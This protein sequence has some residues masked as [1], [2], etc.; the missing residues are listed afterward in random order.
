[1]AALPKQQVLVACPRCGHEQPEHRTAYSTVCKK[2]RQYYRVQEVLHPAVVEPRVLPTHTPDPV[3]ELRQ[4]ACFQC[5]TVLDVPAHAQST[6]CKRCSTHIDLQDHVIN[7]SVSRN[8]RTKGR[9]VVEEKGFLFNTDSLAREVVLR[10]KFLGKIASEDALV[11][12][13]SAQI[14][15]TVTGGMLH[16][17]EGQVFRPAQPVEFRSALVEG[18]FAGHLITDKT[19]ELGRSGLLTGVVQCGGLQIPEGGRL[20]A[21]VSMK[22][23][24]DGSG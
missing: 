16:I 15:G 21:D 14:K 6:M 19:I 22:R 3:Q 23:G 12:Y 2:C 24:P 18:E 11:I 4:I 8:L 13:T 1:M 5:N 7:H 10:G 20:E 9:I 17:P